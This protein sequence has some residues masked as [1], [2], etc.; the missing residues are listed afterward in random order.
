MDNEIQ[1]HNKVKR[2][3]ER[4]VHEAMLLVEHW[5]SLYQ[6]PYLQNGR[7]L[8][9]TLDKAAE[10]VGIPRKTL[11]DYYY[12]LKKA[13]TLVDLQNFKNCKIG[14]IRRIVKESKKQSETTTHLIDT[15]E[16]FLQENETIVNRKNSFEY[17]D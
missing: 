17:D 10:I 12:Q 2:I 8:K 16:F 6:Q 7:Q 5:R 15:N 11:E 1:I 14:V 3:K 4:Y 13:E 9:I